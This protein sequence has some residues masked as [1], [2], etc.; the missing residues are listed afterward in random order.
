VD[1]LRQLHTDLRQGVVPKTVYTV[2]TVRQAAE[3]WLAHG[4]DN[5]SAKTIKKIQNML[6]PILKAIGA[7]K[8]RELPAANVR[9]ALSTIAAE[10]S[11]S[12]ALRSVQLARTCGSRFRWVSSSAHTT[13]RRG[14]SASRL[15]IPATTWS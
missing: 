13:A 1:K 2:Y 7:Q 14:S 5:R 4:L 12:A 15:T 11:S 9:E 8:L 10:Y 6:E 3:D